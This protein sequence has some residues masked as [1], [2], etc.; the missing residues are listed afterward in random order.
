MTP[1]ATN[2]PLPTNTST[3]TLTP[4]KTPLPTNTPL[5]TSTPKPQ[6][7]YI[8]DNHTAYESFG[9]LHIVGEVYN[10]SAD[11]LRYVEVN[12]SAFNSSGQ[13]LANGYG[14]VSVDSLAPWTKGCFSIYISSVGDWAWYTLHSLEYWSDA[15]PPPNITLYNHQGGSG[16]YGY[17]SIVG[18]MRNDDSVFVDYAEAIAILYNSQGKVVG[19]DSGY[20]AI[21]GLNPG[22]AT[23][24]TIWSIL[25]DDVSV[26]GYA[27][28]SDGSK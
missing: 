8:K 5:P 21:Y 14:Y 26:A 1:T 9:Y 3:I 25:E 17:Y 22:Q 18:Q 10:G 28:V 15:D 6:V 19:C 20:G 2:T 11:Y 4:T 24:F 13:L 16:G 23:S 12:A 27:L 7:V